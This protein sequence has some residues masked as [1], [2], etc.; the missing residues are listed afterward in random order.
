MHFYEAR[1][2]L[3]VSYKPAGKPY[4]LLAEQATFAAP[5]KVTLPLD[6]GSLPSDVKAEHIYVVLAYNGMGE[7]LENAKVDLEARTVTVML[8]RAFSLASGDAAGSGAGPVLQ[9]AVNPGGIDTIEVTPRIAWCAAHGLEKA[10]VMLAK[11][12][13]IM[14][15][16]RQNYDPLGMVNLGQ[17]TFTFKPMN[18]A[19]GGLTTGANSVEVNSD[20]FLTYDEQTQGSVFMHEYF[21]MLQLKTIAQNVRSLATPLP[22]DYFLRGKTEWLKEATATWMQENMSKADAAINIPR[23][24]PN[25]CYIPLN[26]Y[27]DSTKGNPHQYAAYIFF[28]WL[29]S[30][31]SSRQVIARAWQESFSGKWVQMAGLEQDAGQGR[32]TFNPLDILDHILRETPDSQ[33]RQRNLREVYAEFLLHYGWLKDFAPLKG[34]A[35]VRS[36]LGAPKEITLVGDKTTSWTL[37]FEEGGKRVTKKSETV[38]GEGFHIARAFMI[39]KGLKGGEKGDLE[40]T[41][42]LGERGDPRDSMIVVFPLKKNAEDPVIGNAGSPAKIRNWHETNGAI[43]WLVDMSVTGQAGLA[44]TAD[45]KDGDEMSFVLEPQIPKEPYTETMAAHAGFMLSFAAPAGI[46]PKT[47][48]GRKQFDPIAD[49]WAKILENERNDRTQ[50]I[51]LVATI[52]GRKQHY[53]GRIGNTNPPALSIFGGKFQGRHFPGRGEGHFPRA[54]ALRDLPRD[55]ETPRLAPARSRRL[56]PAEDRRNRGAEGEGCRA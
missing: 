14:K 4:L 31:Y 24:E 5:V 47:P 35:Q 7:V 15:L 49:K 1:P 34:N 42:K 26:G 40:V 8:E 33:G 25:F 54:G 11:G 41:L 52:D 28:S 48:E 51:H 21:H 55:R 23:L 20:K 46:D 36:V 18:P 56:D 27:E 19:W 53:Y 3:P 43:V 2:R 37:P 10:D 30:M 38:T 22:G 39:A 50:W 44:V 29:D 13:A 45:V 9:P 12:K 32:G 16:V 17:T 6:I